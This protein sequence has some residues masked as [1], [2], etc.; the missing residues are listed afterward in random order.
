LVINRGYGNGKYI[1]NY[2]LLN[3]NKEYLIENHLICI[4][5]TENIN[6]DDL[7][8]LYKKIIESFKNQKT[9]KFVQFYFGNNA[10]NTKELCE[11]LPI[12]L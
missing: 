6:K 8:K 9:Q 4:K 11:M 7:I 1:F 12:Y 2:C 10:I 3:I 5:Y